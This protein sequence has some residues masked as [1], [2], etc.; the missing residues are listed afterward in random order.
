ML[1]LRGRHPWFRAW[2][3]FGCQERFQAENIPDTRRPGY[4]G[5]KED[6]P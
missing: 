6:S 2:A 5:L 1:H 3:P 4:D